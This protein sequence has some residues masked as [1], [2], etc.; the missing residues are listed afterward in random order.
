MDVA[1]TIN[2]HIFIINDLLS[3]INKFEVSIWHY[4]TIK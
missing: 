4:A 2:A 1:S 3:I